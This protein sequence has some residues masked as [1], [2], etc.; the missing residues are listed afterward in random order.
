VTSTP[1]E[2]NLW[3]V[4][5]SLLPESDVAFPFERD[6]VA[7][8]RCLSRGLHQMVVI[9]GHDA[10]AFNSAVSKAF[11]RLLEGRPWMPLQARLCNAE[12]LQ[13]LPMLRRLDD[14]MI[15]GRYDK[16][17]LRRHCG[18]CDSKGT[19]DSLYIAMRF[20]KLSWPRLRN[21]PVYMPGLEACW[22]ADP[23]LDRGGG[24][25]DSNDS[26][27][28]DNAPS[29][30]DIMTPTITN[31][32]RTASE[33]SRSSSFG[34]AAG[35]GTAAITATSEGEGSRPKVARVIPESRRRVET[36]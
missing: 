9:N 33:I 19:I 4:H 36:V 21:A 6:T 2:R 26:A 14:S 32:K 27:I 16:E 13:G 5:I 1:E 24:D 25:F 3:T 35:P 30:G 15:H 8:Q 20:H 12:S 29:A 17:F 11:E 31:L 34:S 23:Y 28:D 18:V 22:A 10:E 7:Y